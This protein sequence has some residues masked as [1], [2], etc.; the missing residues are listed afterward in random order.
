[1][2]TSAGTEPLGNTADEFTAKLMVKIP[3]WARVARQAQI[4][5]D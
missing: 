3:R 1:M 2:I 4:K 5:A